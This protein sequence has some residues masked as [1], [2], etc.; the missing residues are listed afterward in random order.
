MGQVSGNDARPGEQGTTGIIILTKCDQG[1]C[2][3]PK[4]L[5]EAKEKKAQKLRD[6][7]STTQPPS[8]TKSSRTSNRGSSS[9]RFEVHSH[10]LQLDLTHNPETGLPERRTIKFGTNCDLSDEKKWRP[11]IQVG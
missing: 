9:S 11:Q 5:A 1:K 8:R 3:C 4:V 6:K 2:D 7:T 10:L